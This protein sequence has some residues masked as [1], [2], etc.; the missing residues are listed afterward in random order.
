MSNCRNRDEI[1]LIF[2]EWKQSLTKEEIDILFDY[3][4]YL[5][6]EINSSLRE[7]FLSDDNF[8]TCPDDLR[9]KENI[10]KV[11]EI[12]SRFILNEK[13]SVYRNEHHDISL[14][15][16]CYFI[17]GIK[18]IEYKHY[19]STSFTEKASNQFYCILKKHFQDGTFLQ[20]K[21]DIEEGVSCGYLDKDI[22]SMSDEEDEIL[23]IR[24]TIFKIDEDS[25]LI[26][27]KEKTIFISGEFR[28]E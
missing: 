3:S 1:T 16:F 5:Y 14:K 4:K 9:L 19:I 13:I 20:I 18:E 12:L 25:I 24:N 17:Q 26:D 21:G 23:I 22:S 28:K 8:G 27:P 10:Q 11:D 6:E 2:Q 7:D 15:D